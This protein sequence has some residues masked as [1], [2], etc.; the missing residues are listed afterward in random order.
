MLSPL[1]L[2][3]EQAVLLIP[4]GRMSGLVVIGIAGTRLSRDCATA[5]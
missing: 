4:A 3:S 5:T 1:A 2:L